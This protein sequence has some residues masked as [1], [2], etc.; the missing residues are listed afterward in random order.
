[1]S[2]E[3]GLIFKKRRFAQFVRLELCMRMRNAQFQK[4]VGT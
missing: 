2:S 1:M 4:L 3:F